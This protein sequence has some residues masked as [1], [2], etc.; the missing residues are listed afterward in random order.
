MNASG[1]KALLSLRE[2]AERLSVC[3]DTIRTQIKNG[4]LKSVRIGHRVLIPTIEIERVT[5]EGC[6]APGRKATPCISQ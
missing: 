1:E 3:T 4:S 2:A 5:Q 6:L